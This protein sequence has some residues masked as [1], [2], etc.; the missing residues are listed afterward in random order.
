LI[1]F[2]GHILWRKNELS[3]NPLLPL[4]LAFLSNSPAGFVLQ[5]V[6]PVGPDY[7]LQAIVSIT[8]PMNWVVIASNTPA[9]SMVLY[10]DPG[11]TSNSSRF[12]RVLLRP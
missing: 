7:I 6:G 3:V 8:N 12:Y 4:M 2:G 10:T 5:A 9:S 1:V 11:A